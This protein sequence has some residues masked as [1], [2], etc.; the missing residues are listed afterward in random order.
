MVGAFSFHL[1]TRNGSYKMCVKLLRQQL[2]HKTANHYQVLK[3]SKL[4]RTLYVV[5][6]FNHMSTF[7]HHEEQLKHK[8]DNKQEACPSKRYSMHGFAC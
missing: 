2:R 7:K 4:R 8:Q 6:H 5:A 3:F 1:S